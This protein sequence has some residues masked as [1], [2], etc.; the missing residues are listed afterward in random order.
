MEKAAGGEVPI[1]FK[2]HP[3]F[4]APEKRLKMARF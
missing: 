1:P 3:I 2:D 4:K